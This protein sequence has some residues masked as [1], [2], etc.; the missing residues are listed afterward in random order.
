MQTRT[1]DYQDTIMEMGRE[2]D[3]SLEL[4]NKL[5]NFTCHLY[6]LKTSC[7]KVNELRYHLFCA[8]KG[9]VESHLLPPCKDCLVQHALQSNFQAAIWQ[10]CLGQ[11]PSMTGQPASQA[12]LDL[13][14]CNCAKKV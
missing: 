13:L 5:E 8:K 9:E 1:K 10:R 12:I 2:W 11:N 7:T 4:I 3:V 6:T 14:A